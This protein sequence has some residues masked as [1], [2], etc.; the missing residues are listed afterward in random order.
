MKFYP[1]DAIEA[2]RPLIACL[3][4]LSI[5][6][7]FGGSI[8]SS[9]HGTPRSTIDADIVADIQ[10]NLADDLYQRLK[11][12]Y[13]ADLTSIRKATEM[14]ES[15]NLLHR[16]T[17]VKIDVFV[18]RHYRYERQVMERIQMI[19]FDSDRADDRLPFCSVE[20]IILNKL[21]WYDQGGRI[22]E[23]QWSDLQGVLKIQRNALDRA[24]LDHW[25]NYLDVSGLLRDAYR[26][27]GLD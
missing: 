26:Q 14:R 11:P 4:A 6:C 21:M 9:V 1:S 3:Q 5:P 12:I 17:H 22:S 7:Y 10:P 2:S 19:A 8:A 20:D 18:Q 15:F 16:E 23:R 24:Y 27:A 13:F 25:A